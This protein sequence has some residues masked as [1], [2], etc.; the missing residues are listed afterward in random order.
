MLRQ[1]EWVTIRRLPDGGLHPGYL[2]FSG[3][4]VLEVDLQQGEIAR[5]FSPGDLVEIRSS[6][7]LYLG[8]LQSCQDQQLR[9]AVEHA[10][11]LAALA[12][13]K[14]VWQRPVTD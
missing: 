13:I 11:D 14:Q 10:V 9:I 7:T 12:S 3:A 2:H 6:G 5:E 8:E 4:Q 1:E